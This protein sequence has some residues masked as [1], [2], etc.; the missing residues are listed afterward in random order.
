MRQVPEAVLRQ[1]RARALIR[2]MTLR[3]VVLMALH[4]AGLVHEPPEPAEIYRRT[5]AD[6]A[7]NKPSRQAAIPQLGLMLDA[8]VIAAIRSRASKSGLTER[9]VLLKALAED[10]ITIEADEYRADKRSILRSGRRHYASRNWGALK[11]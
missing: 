11:A 2:G 9:G 6:V 10:G 7:G 4:K 1:V 5:G 3:G 8:R